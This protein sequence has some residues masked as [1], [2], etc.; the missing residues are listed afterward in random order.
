MLL[1][2]KEEGQVHDVAQI[3][4]A[5]HPG[6][7]RALAAPAAQV[8]LDRLGNDVRIDSQQ[9]Y[10]RRSGIAEESVDGLQDVEHLALLCTVQPVHNHNHSGRG[11]KAIILATQR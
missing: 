9:D 3:S 7:R 4:L 6:P 5:A 11:E 1:C 8:A 10:E 2:L